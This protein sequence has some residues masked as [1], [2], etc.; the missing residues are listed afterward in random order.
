M[1]SFISKIESGSYRCIGF[2]L[3]GTLYDEFDFIQQAYLPVSQAIAENLRV[4]KEVV[5]SE[6][7]TEWLKHGSSGNIFQ[8]V[9]SKYCKDISSELVSLCVSKFRNA[10]FNL[11]L[12]GRAIMTLDYL[13][14]H[15][16]EMFIVTDGNSNLQRRKIRSLNLDN[17]FSSDRIAVSGDY[18]KEFQ[19]PCPFMISKIKKQLCEPSEVLYVGDRQCDADFAANCGY[20]FIY[21][22]NMNPG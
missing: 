19:K 5:F 18:G 16:Y 20:D 2:D 8:L 9:I 6:L 21:L 1:K 11:E 10:D 15:G 13:Q 14:T 17:W 7:C 3:D 22:K 12:S 4:D